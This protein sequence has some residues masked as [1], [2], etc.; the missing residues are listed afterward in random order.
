MPVEVDFGMHF[1]TA[2]GNNGVGVELAIDVR[3]VG[4]NETQMIY[5][6]HIYG[7]T[8]FTPPVKSGYAHYTSDLKVVINVQTV[9][10]KFGFNLQFLT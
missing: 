8:S 4:G 10:G 1:E 2:D 3:L 6:D 5:S 9:N 7:G